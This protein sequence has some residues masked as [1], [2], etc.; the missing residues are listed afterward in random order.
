MKSYTHVS[1]V[2]DSTIEEVVEIFE[3]HLPRECSGYIRSLRPHEIKTTDDHRGRF[4]YFSAAG[5]FLCWGVEKELL[6]A[7][8]TS[9]GLDV[10]QVC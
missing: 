6:L 5:Q 9:D 2:P 8:V 1:G 4:G 3:R 10:H 7:R